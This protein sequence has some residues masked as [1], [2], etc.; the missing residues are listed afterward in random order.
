MEGT[1]A[2]R[3]RQTSQEARSVIQKAAVSSLDQGGDGE[4]G[5]K[6]LVA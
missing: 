1:E 4:G 5:G 3:S 6:L 2:G